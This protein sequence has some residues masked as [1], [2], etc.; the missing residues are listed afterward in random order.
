MMTTTTRPSALT[1][2]ALF[3]TKCSTYLALTHVW[4]VKYVASGFHE[5]IGDVLALSV[6]TPEHMEKIGLLPDYVP[7]PG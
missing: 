6:S 2:T 5:A 3:V 7:D 1:L 4:N